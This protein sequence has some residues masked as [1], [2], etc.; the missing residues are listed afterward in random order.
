MINL[1]LVVAALEEMLVLSL[2]DVS[3]LLLVQILEEAYA[4]QPILTV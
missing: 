4:S 1:D 3:L 2:P